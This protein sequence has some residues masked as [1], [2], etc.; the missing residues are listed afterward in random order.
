MAKRGHTLPDNNHG[1]EC[2]DCR[3]AVVFPCTRETLRPAES[4][5][6]PVAAAAAV[7]A[8][9][10]AVPALPGAASLRL[11]QLSCRPIHCVSYLMATAGA[12]KTGIA[13][14]IL[15][16]CQRISLSLFKKKMPKKIQFARFQSDPSWLSNYCA[17]FLL[18]INFFRLFVCF[19]MEMNQ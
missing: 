17:N 6:S 11:I 16:S 9:V 7:A 4:N 10:A 1:R 5:E 13:R 14:K 18:F 3:P 15:L 8:G 2:R 19:E 12:I